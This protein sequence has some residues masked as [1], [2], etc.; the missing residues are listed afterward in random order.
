ME[1]TKLN[2]QIAEIEISK[3]EL[4][5]LRQ[6]CNEACHGITIDNF[7]HTIGISKSEAKQIFSYFND[8]EKKISL[9]SSIVHPKAEKQKNKADKKVNRKKCILTSEKNTF[10]FYIREL[11]F[12][13]Q[14]V[15]ILAAIQENDKVLAKTD[16]CRIK[17]KELQ[18]ELTSLKEG[19]NR[20][21]YKKEFY[22]S[23]SFLNEAVKLNISNSDFNNFKSLD[24]VQVA[25]GFVFEIGKQ[26]DYSN[27]QKNFMS[28]TST[29]NILDFVV[30]VENF[31][32]SIS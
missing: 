29:K 28:I 4:F 6:I 13:K 24:E 7:E 2:T 10:V 31:L 21:N 14:Q 9:G 19:I 15:G 27:E 20:F 11:D 1:I 16:A 18:Q 26:F 32:S 5:A 25:I 8:L 17:I 23:Y 22:A 12:T 3:H 30:S